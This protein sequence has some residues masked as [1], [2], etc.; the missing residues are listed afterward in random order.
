MFYA[1]QDFG[2]ATSNTLY[3]FGAP[4]GCS[5]ASRHASWPTA[6]ALAADRQ[7]QYIAISVISQWEARFPLSP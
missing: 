4:V 5:G 6:V 2:A 3:A 1:T 7:K